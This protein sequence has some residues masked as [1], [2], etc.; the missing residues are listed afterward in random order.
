MISPICA[1]IPFDNEE[2]SHWILN[3]VIK[4]HKLITDNHSN[5]NTND[6]NNSNTND[7][8]YSLVINDEQLLQY[9][10]TNNLN[11]LF[12]NV[13][14]NLSKKFDNYSNTN[15]KTQI[16]NL[17]TLDVIQYV[18]KYLTIPNFF[19]LSGISHSWLNVIYR[20]QAF[21]IIH[22]QCMKQN[23]DYLLRLINFDRNWRPTI[24]GAARFY[25]SVSRGN[26]NDNEQENKNDSN[27]EPCIHDINSIFD[28]L[29][30]SSALET[31][32]TNSNYN[33]TI[34]IMPIVI[35]MD[36]Y[37]FCN[38]FNW[39]F[40]Y[41]SKYFDF[42]G[43][44]DIASSMDLKESL[45]PCGY[46]VIAQIKFVVKQQVKNITMA[47]QM[48]RVL[49]GTHRSGYGLSTGDQKTLKNSKNI[50]VF[51]SEWIDMV[52]D[53]QVLFDHFSQNITFSI[54][55]EKLNQMSN[56]W[57]MKEKIRAKVQKV[58]DEE[59]QIVVKGN[60]YDSE[61]YV[62]GAYLRI[63]LTFCDN[64]KSTKVKSGRI[65]DE[66]PVS[67]ESDEFYL[68]C[69]ENTGMDYKLCEKYDEY[70]SKLKLNEQNASITRFHIHCCTI[71][72]A[73]KLL[74]SNISEDICFAIKKCNH[75]FYNDEKIQKLFI[76]N[77]Y[78]VP[79]L[80]SLLFNIGN[81][82]KHQFK[83]ILG[84]NTD[85]IKILS[86]KSQNHNYFTHGGYSKIG[87]SAEIFELICISIERMFY[88][89]ESPQ[90]EDLQT[91]AIQLDW[92]VNIK[93]NHF[94]SQLLN[95][96]LYFVFCHI[97]Q[98]KDHLFHLWDQHKHAIINEK[99]REFF[100]NIGYCNV[101]KHLLYAILQICHGNEKSKINF[102]HYCFKKCQPCLD[103]FILIYNELMINGV[104]LLSK[105][106]QLSQMTGGEFKSKYAVND[107]LVNPHVVIK[108]CLSLLRFLAVLIKSK[109]SNNYFTKD[110][111][112]QE[113]VLHQLMKELH[114][115]FVCY[116]DIPIHENINAAELKASRDP[117]RRCVLYCQLFVEN[118]Q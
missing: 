7:I 86:P 90:I 37:G 39:Q 3:S 71:S 117:C 42:L 13:L 34:N 108:Y 26:N 74:F 82:L 18:L 21:Y 105:Y 80:L 112:L 75:Y 78:L 102:L 22:K 62:T 64:K 15:A 89:W 111:K 110:S 10:C 107:G 31:T 77:K 79:K 4:Y 63:V 19:S 96:N 115:V 50:N 5:N 104:Y 83:C 40:I 23:R 48:D 1:F 12:G 101:R 49:F 72:D 118:F 69:I 70:I 94:Y 95:D 88:S 92:I 32:L 53:E 65:F 114:N 9:P 56:D 35:N 43:M 109:N 97:L 20:S 99:K 87:N 16:E 14:N 41:L 76:T 29:E 24:G 67:I 81:R 52:E 113:N 27:V 91:G 103:I 44:C 38:R 73:M 17:L 58:A 66:F 33:N 55:K 36:G 98:C 2:D 11:L 54:N 116:R 85:N 60:N 57:M 61:T 30:E 100:A 46:H 45:F 68:D 47:K 84:E 6:D 106:D 59:K 51:A 28:E 8:N 25:V 93:T